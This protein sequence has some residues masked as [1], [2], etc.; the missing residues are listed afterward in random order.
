VR[1]N[2]YRAFISYSHGGDAQ[3]AA[4]LH[5]ALERVAKPWFKRSSI[6]IFRDETSLSASPGLWTEIQTNLGRCEYFILMASVASAASRWVNLEVD[7]W[8]T[9]RTQA[10]LLI[11]VTDGQIVRTSDGSDFDW[12]R[13]T[14][15]PDVLRGRFRQEPLWVDMRSPKA[16]DRLSA[17]SPRFRDAVLTLAARLHGRSKDELDSA[18]IREHRRLR[19]VGMLALMVVVGSAGSALRMYSS[20]RH[21]AQRADSNWREAQSRRL[22]ALAMTTLH[23]DKNI[24]EAIQLAVLAWRLDPTQ[25]SQAALRQMELASADVAR[26]LGHHTGSVV[27]LAFSRD[28]SLLAS[29]A[30][31]G[32]IL[33]WKTATLEAGPRLLAG[34]LK[35]MSALNSGLRFDANGQRLLAWSQHAA[36]EVWDLARGERSVELPAFAPQDDVGGAAFSGDGALAAY[37]ADHRLVMWD[38]KQRKPVAVPRQLAAARTLAIHFTPDGDLL[39]L[40]RLADSFRAAAWKPDAGSVNLGP[41]TRPDYSSSGHSFG[42]FAPSGRSLALAL[43]GQFSLWQIDPKLALRRFD[44][45]PDSP[46]NYDQGLACDLDSSSALIAAE[47]STGWRWEHWRAGNPWALHA[48]GEIHGHK[49]TWSPDRRWL[50]SVSQDKIVVT[51]LQPGPNDRAAVSLSARCRQSDYQGDDGCWRSLC[52][53]IAPSLREDKLRSLFGIRDYEVFYETFRS[54]IDASLCDAR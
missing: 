28:S 13:T 16:G 42:C 33:V 53:K 19:L 25:E 51:A 31:D 49:L 20:G 45:P 50:A 34:G 18:D 1:D 54:R 23:G 15:L 43:D 10:R 3:L 24:N 40:Q 22:A 8:L 21:E 35:G 36:S 48:S 32:S 52:R 7:W 14:C 47:S 39:A 6:R 46:H 44:L 4:A 5:R 38:L 9:N 41:P 2:H 30:Q 37:I 17:K 27:A 11:V 26:I 12:T 29:M